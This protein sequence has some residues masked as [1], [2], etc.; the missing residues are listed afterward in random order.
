M[1]PADDALPVLDTSFHTRP[2]DVQRRALARTLRRRAFAL[3]ME[4]GLGK[5]KVV[6]DTCWILYERSRFI[7]A[8][9]VLAP[10]DV[11][12]Q[13]CNEQVPAHW[14]PRVAH[15]T[16]VWDAARAACERELKFLLKRPLRNEFLIAAFNHEALATARGRNAVRALLTAYDCAF[17]LD[18]SHEFKGHRSSRA[19]AALALA[20]LSKVR[21]V[22]SGT[23]RPQSPFDLYTQYQFLDPRILQQDSFTAFKHRYGRFV[24][25]WVK[26]KS[27]KGRGHAFESLVEYQRLDELYALTD[28]F[29]FRARKCDSLDLPPKLYATRAT[30]LSAEQRGL[31][32]QMDAEGA[33]LL[34]RAEA[35]ALRVRDIPAW[36][37]ADEEAERELQ[38]VL[39]SAD[40]AHASKRMT[41]L[42][43]LT[44]KMRLQQI[45]GGFVTTDAKTTECIHA[46]FGDV[47]RARTL[48]DIVGQAVAQ[49]E[50]ESGRVIVWGIFRAEL[51][52]IARL[53][54]EAFAG[55]DTVLIHGKVTGEA[56]ARAIASFK[57]AS[58]NTRILVAHP[59]TMG[60]GQN[61]QLGRTMAYYSNS[62]A[63][64]L[65]AQSEERSHR[66]G[67]A[68]CVT[69]YDIVTRGAKREDSHVLDTLR[70]HRAESD[71]FMAR[72]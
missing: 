55:V 69:I 2:F 47:P 15:R 41:A 24:R 5:S 1:E 68:G 35:G 56:R 3:Y 49:P 39:T 53:F 62:Y 31:Y 50:E 8:L 65:R 16:F 59:R 71:K 11:H 61:L 22:L 7:N 4:Q 26:S 38:D 9:V 19:R 72:K 25:E 45:V 20:P 46:R 51:D 43:R 63:Y 13:W 66:M 48:L 33:V 29:T 60:T 44:I 58:S 14:P 54:D 34:E 27:D 67:V 10:N 6:L 32:E 36:A 42:L 70:E 28:R 52:A 37:F 57:D 64:R 30:H 40:A 23:A 21:R 17:V 12:E 18:E